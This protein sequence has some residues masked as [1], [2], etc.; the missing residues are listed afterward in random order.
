MRKEKVL[1]AGGGFLTETWRESGLSGCARKV[2]AAIRM[3]L[4]LLTLGRRTNAS[5]GAYFD[6]ITD[7]ARMF[8]GDNF[9][10]GYYK[11][12]AENLDQALANHTDIVAEMAGLSSDKRVLDLGCGICAPAIRMARMHGCR[13][14]CVNISAEQVRQGRAHVEEH[15][16]SRSIDV[17]KGNALDLDFAD[18]SFDSIVCLEVA[19]DICVTDA[20]KA[21]LVCE[22]RRVL[23]AGGSV[24][25]SDLVFTGKPARDEERAMRA[26]LYHEGAELV[27]DWPAIFEANGFTISRKMDII[28]DTMKTWEHSLAVYESRAEEVDRRYGKRI[29][30]RTLEQLRLIPE[31]LRKHGS[32]VVMS[33]QKRA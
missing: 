16:L 23:K 17:M 15:G 27:T 20:Q 22:M 11:S 3:S 13:L 18:G 9:H 26:I 25:F 7:D 12:G 6:L 29:A 5:V 30:R 4:P 1:A 33:V 2:A 21:R 14:A 31:I 24:G 19:G 10:F 8:Y 32:F 28:D